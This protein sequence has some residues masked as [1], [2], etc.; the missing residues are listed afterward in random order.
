MRFGKLSTGQV[1]GTRSTGHV[2][3][4]RSAGP[5]PHVEG[6]SADRVRATDRAARKGT[7]PGQ[8]CLIFR[9][10][11][12]AVWRRNEATG[13]PLVERGR[14][15]REG[16]GR[17]TTK[18]EEDPCDLA[19]KPWRSAHE[20]PGTRRDPHER[21]QSA[22]GVPH[23]VWWHRLALQPVG[24]PCG[25]PRLPFFQCP[26]RHLRSEPRRC[27][28]CPAGRKPARNRLTNRSS[29]ATRTRNRGRYACSRAKGQH[30]THP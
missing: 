2:A 16:A 29:D 21:P 27:A 19:L 10:P 17:W 3:A 9:T 20:T 11:G 8:R 5:G 13:L 1:A 30:G 6:G 18:P 26:E 15:L 4:T 14:H 7:V 22:A 25:R 12:P 28:M 24:Q 23:H